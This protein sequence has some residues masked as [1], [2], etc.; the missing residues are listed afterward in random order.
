MAGKFYI[1]K[2]RSGEYRWR[3]KSRNGEVV[4]SGE[5][6]KT[7]AGARAAVQAVQRAAAGA[8]VVN[9]EDED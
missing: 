6:Y 2:D 9:D 3:L 1:Y 5:S 7:R 4:A 8:E